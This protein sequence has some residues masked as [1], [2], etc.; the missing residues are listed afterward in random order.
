[1]VIHV[2]WSS[3][4]TGNDPPL[5]AGRVAVQRV[6]LRTN[7]PRRTTETET[8]AGGSGHGAGTA[9]GPGPETGNE[10]GG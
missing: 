4:T 5:G 2:L 3:D 1:M 10:P 7:D 6:A 8:G 9:A